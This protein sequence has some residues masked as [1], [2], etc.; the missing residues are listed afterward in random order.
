MRSQNPLVPMGLM[1]AVLLSAVSATAVPNPM[2]KGVSKQ[3][4][5]AL[6]PPP[7]NPMPAGGTRT[8]GGG[9]GD[10]S[11]CPT[12]PIDLTAITPATVQGQTLL[13]HPTFWFYVPYSADD[14]ATGEFSILTADELTRVYKTAFKLPEQPGFISITLP[15]DEVPAL[16]EG[17]YYHWYLELACGSDGSVATDPN[18]D[19][20]VQRLPATPELEAAVADLSPDV[21]Y[22]S[23]D[24]LAQQLKSEADVQQE[25]ANLLNSV[26]LG[27]LVQEPLVG[28]VMLL[29]NEAVAEA[30]AE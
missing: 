2:N 7:S 20:W 19:G 4:K 6:P 18:I 30:T 16:Q 9:L 21:W 29:D 8:P 13:G 17:V 22:D 28:P 23:L 5:Q 24:S 12:K 15:A 27:N 11:L 25:W 1:T 10:P 26:G 3:I 14:V